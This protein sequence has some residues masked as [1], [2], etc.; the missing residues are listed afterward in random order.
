MYFTVPTGREAVLKTCRDV[1]TY[2][3]KVSPRGMPTKELLFY[4]FRVEDSSDTI[5]DGINR[6]GLQPA[7]GAAEA[8][9]IIAGEKH[10][11]LMHAISKWFPKPVTAKRW[12]SDVAAYGERLA[13]Q[14]PAIVEKLQEDPD[15]REAVG[16]IW[17]QDELTAGQP[18]NLCTMSLQFMR[19]D[20][21]LLCFAN[22]RSNDVWYG[23]CYNIF[24]FTQTQHTI[25]NALG[26]SAGPYFHTAASMHLY[27]R[28]W[29]QASA[30]TWP[31]PPKFEPT[32]LY[33][34][35]YMKCGWDEIAARA[36]DILN[37]TELKDPTWT[38]QW[39]IDTLAPFHEALKA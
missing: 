6:E 11:A 26:I 30:V 16:I 31:P 36:A 10:P 33:G 28:H 8:L 4:T 17:T 27:E 2:G 23:L 19:R 21:E 37:G 20:D 7:I 9:M 13:D 3:K 22:M 15:T 34:I 14:M 5:P 32:R 39:Y 18:H 24:M 12:E 38:E 35:G 1:I 29:E 25:A